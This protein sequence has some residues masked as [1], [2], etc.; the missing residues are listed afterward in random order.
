MILLFLAS[1]SAVGDDSCKQTK[2]G[3]CFVV[4]GRYETYADAELI[5]IIGTHNKLMVDD[6]WETVSAA[7]GDDPEGYDHY[8]VGKFTVCPLERARPGEMRRVCVRRVTSLR[9]IPRKA[10]R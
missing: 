10:S 5:W 1:L 6:G 8:V 2:F 9:R 4:R 7:F 3:S